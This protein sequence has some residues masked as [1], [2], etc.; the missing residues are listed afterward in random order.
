V[1]E[2]FKNICGRISMKNLVIRILLLLLISLCS[3]KKDTT[4]PDIV[5]LNYKFNDNQSA[6]YKLCV[7]LD[8]GVF[9][10]CK[11]N[12]VNMLNAMNCSY[13]AINRDSIFNG[14]LNNYNVLIMPGGDMWQYGSNLSIAG[15][16]KIKN[17]VS[18]GGG[19]IGICGGAYFAANLIVWR[20]WAN[21]PRV[22][23]S[24]SG[25]NLFQ[26][27]AD[28]PIED[29]APSYVDINCQIAIIKKGN[30]IVTDLPDFISPYYDHGPMFLFND[31]I[32]IATLGRT[33]VGNKK[34][35]LFFKY[36]A[37][38]VF[39]TGAHPEADNSRRSWVLIKNA[40]EQCSK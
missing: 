13:T 39:L 19:Y 17:Y 2:S 18:Q 8:N 38:K 28:G 36:N 4:A 27:T 10:G 15:M 33:I 25:L 3:C 37:G 35:L 5:I 7:Y 9:D 1:N 29:F 21:Q 20:G 31:S 34:I 14:A 24:M 32:N 30:P 11:T 12:T 26:G 23:D 22:Y 6:N 16:A 40:I